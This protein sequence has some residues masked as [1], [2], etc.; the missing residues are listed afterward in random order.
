[1]NIHIFDRFTV[2]IS[3]VEICETWGFLGF[4][5]IPQNDVRN[6]TEL[7][8]TCTELPGKMYGCVRYCTELVRLCG[9]FWAHV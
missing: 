5:K 1:M 7:Y 4:V 9:G 6:C 8:G 3:V 2:L